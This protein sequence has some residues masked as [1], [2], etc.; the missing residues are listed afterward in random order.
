MP[1]AEEHGHGIQHDERDG[2]P[3]IGP[4]ALPLQEGGHGDAQG[5]DG[6]Q[7]AH[8]HQVEHRDGVHGVGAHIADGR[9]EAGRRREREAEDAVNPRQAQVLDTVAGVEREH[10][11]DDQVCRG[12][13]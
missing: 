9:A 6:L 11:G 13:A 7:V 10:A 8:G 12:A 1:V 5:V 3:G 4:H 2:R